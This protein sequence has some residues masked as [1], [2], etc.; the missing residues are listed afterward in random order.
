MQ[1]E[2]VYLKGAHPGSDPLQRRIVC[3]ANDVRVR[4]SKHRRASFGHAC[5]FWV[6]TVLQLFVKPTDSVGP[7]DSGDSLRALP[8]E[9]APEFLQAE[10]QMSSACNVWCWMAWLPQLQD[11]CLALWGC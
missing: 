2:C 1:E 5:L 4:G 8:L 3:M 9:M 11:A 6:I 10:V 7:C